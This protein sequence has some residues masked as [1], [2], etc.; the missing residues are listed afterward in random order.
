V[1]SLK[2]ELRQRLLFTL[3]TAIPIVLLTVLLA[4]VILLERRSLLNNIIILSLG[5]FATL[6]YLYYM[7]FF[8]VRKK[9]IDEI[10]GA[11]DRAYFLRLL[12]KRGDGWLLL[13]SI[14]NIKE[15]NERY[16]FENGDKILRRFARILDRFFLERC[17]KEVPIAR[18]KSGDFLVL[19]DGECDA[20]ELLEELLERYDNS[21]INNIE[22]KLFGA[23]TPVEPDLKPQQLI[24]RLYEE[25]YYCKGRC[26]QRIKREPKPAKHKSAEEFDR[27]IT[28]IV[29]QEKFSFLF[30]PALNLKTGAY[31]LVELIVK[32]VDEEGQLIHPSKY[33]PAINRLGLEN[34]FDLALARRL[35]ETIAATPLPKDVAYSFNI[36]PYS[37][38]N[39]A[40]ER[41]F[42]EL[43]AGCSVPRSSFVIKL[44]ESSVYKDTEIYARIIDGYRKEGFRFGFDNF[45]ACNA[46]IEY[47]KEIDVDYLFFD[48]LYTKRLDAPR[49]AALLHS[50]I[51]FATKLGIKSVVKFIDDAQKIETVRAMGADYALGYAVARPMAAGELAAF[52]KERDAIRRG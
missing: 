10:T 9:V 8:D 29:E 18:F 6:Y 17:G 50:W 15:I 7:I 23:A 36:S 47:I 41:R 16:G 5:L 25:I 3:R 38:R 21:F 20:K 11:F 12:A 33:I 39:R 34:R 46:A 32:L 22:I 13:V 45:G 26:R 4:A 35:L 37:I 40:F 28:E 19:L 1:Y 44:L 30:Q 2:Q 43:F 31:D 48:K 51:E 27:L 52:L 42:R 14:D 49:Y 24:D